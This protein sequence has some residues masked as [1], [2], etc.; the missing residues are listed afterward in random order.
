MMAEAYTALILTFDQ[1]SGPF[2]FFFF[3]LSS[4]ACPFIQS[5]DL[6]TVS[7]LPLFHQ[8]EPGTSS[9]LVLVPVLREF[10]SRS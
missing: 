10:D 7:Q 5:H 4:N 3:A 9:L 8:K 2:F 1:T 6:H